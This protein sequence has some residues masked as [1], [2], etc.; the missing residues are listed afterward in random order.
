[1]AK[2]PNTSYTST[3]LTDA[4]NAELTGRWND[5]LANAQLPTHYVTPDFFVD[6]FAGRDRRFAVLALAG[7]RI[8]AVVTGIDDGKTL[9]CGLG[10]RPQMIFR[11]GI[12][13]AKAAMAIAN[14]LRQISPNAELIDLHSWDRI[15]G[16]DTAGYAHKPGSGGDTVAM[17]DLAKGPEQLFKEFSERRRTD[18]RKTMKLGVVTVKPLET[19]VELAAT[20]RI[21]REWTRRKGIAADTHEAFR[22]MLTSKYRHT[23]IAIHEKEVI[24]ATYLRFCPGGVVEY[25]ANNSLEESQKLRANELLGWRSIEWACENGF[26]HFSLGAAHPFLARFG[27]DLVA[28]HRYRLDRTMLKLHVNRERILQFAVKTYLALPDGIRSRIKAARAS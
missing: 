14:G 16:F 25:A 19:E 5:L 28:S 17:L 9:R 26:T 10:V 8:D 27:G 20:Y 15:A 18:L 22:S 1:M 21:H 24:A 13:T 11:R 12:D 23:L 6:P 2:M 7:D 3:I 4:P